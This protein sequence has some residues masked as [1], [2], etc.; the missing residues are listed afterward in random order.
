MLP[1]LPHRVLYACALL[2]LASCALLRPQFE[3]PQITVASVELRGGNLLRQDFVVRLH[4]QNPNDRDLPVQGV[5]A[6]LSVEGDAVASGASTQA[7]LVPAR[8]AADVDV[9][10]TANLLLAAARLGN[11]FSAGATAIGYDIT[12]TANIDLPFMGSLAFHQSGAFSLNQL[13]LSH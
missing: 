12:G 8:G 2:G 7:F 6:D 4:V 5:H 1:R 10:V 11:K 9:T 3:R 13:G